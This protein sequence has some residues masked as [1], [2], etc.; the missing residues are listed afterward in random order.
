[1]SPQQCWVVPS[2]EFARY[3]G[4]EGSLDLEAAAPDGRKLKAVLSLYRNA[5]RLIGDGA[6]RP[7]VR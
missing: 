3:A 5:W 2:S 1:V 7:F 6:R 4:P